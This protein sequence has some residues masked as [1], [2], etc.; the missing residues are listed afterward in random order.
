MKIVDKSSLLLKEQVFK[1]PD[2]SGQILFFY[3]NEPNKIN[4]YLDCPNSNKMR[5]VIDLDEYSP[6]YFLELFHTSKRFDD[7]NK[8]METFKCKSF[9]DVS[10]GNIIHFEGS[11][12]Q[13]NKF[14]FSFLYDK[15][16]FS[17]SF[18][19]NSLIVTKSNKPIFN[20]DLL[21]NDLPGIYIEFLSNGLNIFDSC[22]YNKTAKGFWQKNMFESKF[23][24]WFS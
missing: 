23:V 24:L 15:E 6:I 4:V 12:T 11:P 2:I 20:I 18:Q 8:A 14:L 3:F 22:P 13:I 1:L 17:L 19:N 21:I 5:L 7:L 16:L 10:L 9:I